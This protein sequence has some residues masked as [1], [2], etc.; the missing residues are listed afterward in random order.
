[1][2]ERGG[3]SFGF[4]RSFWEEADKLFQADRS[5]FEALWSSVLPPDIPPPDLSAPRWRTALDGA[6]RGEEQNEVVEAEPIAATRR[7]ADGKRK[8]PAAPPAYVT[9]HFVESRGSF[10]YK[11][12]PDVLAFS[13]R[14]QSFRAHDNSV[15]TATAIMEMAQQR[16]W[17]SVRVRGA[18]DFRRAVWAAAMERGLQVGGY[19]PTRGETALLAQSSS[20]DGH[21]ERQKR[22]SK[23]TEKGRTGDPSLTGVIID[24]GAAPYQ[25]DSHNS[26]SFY[27]TL[28]DRDGTQSTHWGVGLQQAIEHSGANV[29]QRVRLARFGAIPVEVDRTV[30][31]DKGD[32]SYRTPQI[33]QRRVWE[34]HLLDKT[35][36]IPEGGKDTKESVAP[37]RDPQLEKALK[38]I[39]AR[40][41]G[42]TPQQRAEFRQHFD[43][44][45]AR[46][47]PPKQSKEDSRVKTR[48]ARSR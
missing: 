4:D 21:P 5:D 44:A 36:K 24:M 32:I 23:N 39:E 18:T 45:Y 38:I 6:G 25:H 43:Q 29:G 8:P 1:V 35:R 7:V 2:R 41:P 42:L 34:V 3:E 46:M 14:G 47:S 16:G 28:R 13:V 48:E 11:Q 30:R 37:S 17:T 19:K 10:Y 22:E 12:R 15:M 31:D 40:L 27:V 33:V 20:P 26:R 9:R